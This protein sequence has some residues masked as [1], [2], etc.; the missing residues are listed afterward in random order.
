MQLN[1]QDNHK[2]PSRQPK[3]S[4]NSKPNPTQSSPY[5]QNNSYIKNPCP[6]PYP[7]NINYL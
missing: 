2:I 1:A 6:S 5:F 4:S 3:I 7:D